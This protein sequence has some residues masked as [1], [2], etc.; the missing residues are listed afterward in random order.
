VSVH[1]STQGHDKILIEP[2]SHRESCLGDIFGMYFNLM[3][4]GAE[5]NLGE[6]LG[7]H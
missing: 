3:I 5:I 7:S 4:S 6:H 1:L 2:I